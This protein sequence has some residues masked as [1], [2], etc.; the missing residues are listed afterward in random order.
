MKVFLFSSLLSSSWVQTKLLFSLLSHLDSARLL[1][2]FRVARLPF[3]SLDI[4]NGNWRE[5]SLSVARARWSKTR[6]DG[7]LIRWLLRS[8]SSIEW[9]RR[10]SLL[11]TEVHIPVSLFSVPFT[12]VTSACPLSRRRK[13]REILFQNNRARKKARKLRSDQHEDVTAWWLF[14]LFLLVV[15]SPPSIKDW[16]RR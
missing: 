4:R 11:V 7:D 5:A 6:L 3:H 16:H 9:T 14:H 12:R 8:V 10:I 15:S 13:R 1:S 2:L